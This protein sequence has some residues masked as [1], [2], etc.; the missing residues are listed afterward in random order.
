MSLVP[1]EYYTNKEYSISRIERFFRKKE[2]KKEAKLLIKKIC[3]INLGRL[4]SDVYIV[5]TAPEL[6]PKKEDKVLVNYNLNVQEG[7]IEDILSK[8]H[9]MSYIADLRLVQILI[10]YIPVSKEKLEKINQIDRYASRLEKSIRGIYIG[11]NMRKKYKILRD[12]IQL[13]KKVLEKYIETLGLKE[14][15]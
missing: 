9:Y 5:A 12:D 8:L 4:D 13:Q 2:F 7:R 1:E 6:K 15:K 3:D 10:R 11:K 14:L